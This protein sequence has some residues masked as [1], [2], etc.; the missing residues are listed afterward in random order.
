MFPR[1][2]SFAKLACAL[3]AALCLLAGACTARKEPGVLTQSQAAD[4]LRK[5]DAAQS[6]SDP[7]GVAAC[8]SRKLRYKMTFKGFGPTET[9]AGDYRE[10]MEAT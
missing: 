8:L 9:R 5:W 4:L 1:H 6:N 7:A 3:A 2:P 10:Y